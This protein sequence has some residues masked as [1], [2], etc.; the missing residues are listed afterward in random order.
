MSFYLGNVGIGAPMP[1]TKLDTSGNTNTS[2]DFLTAGK[3]RTRRVATNV[4]ITNSTPVNIQINNSLDYVF[5]VSPGITATININDADYQPGQDINI[6]INGGAG[7]KMT[8]SGVTIY[9]IANA[10][11]ALAAD[12]VANYAGNK[13]MFALYVESST[14]FNLI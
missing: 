6:N 9:E 11:A 8:S 7:L 3:Y 4:N 12:V 14:K 5:T 1:T 2:L 10:G 13:T